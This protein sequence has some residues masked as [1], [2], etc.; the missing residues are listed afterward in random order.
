MKIGIVCEGGGMRGSYT[1]GV[2]EAFM[3][4]GFVAD[5]LVGVSAG[6]SNG[7]SYVSGQQGRGIRTNLDYCN[8]KRYMGVRSY[9]KTGSFFGM[10]FIFGEIPNKL[11]PFDWEAF[12]ASPCAFYAGVTDVETGRAVFFGKRDIRPGLAVL[13][14]SCSI[15]VLSP[16]VHYNGGQYLD[17]GV[18]APIPIDKALEDGC[19]RLV[20]ILTRQRGYR[21]KPQHMR[22]LYKRRFANHPD[23]EKAIG[24]RY[25][26]YNHT[27][28]RLE[29][30]E[31]EGKAIVIAPTTQLPVD[32]MARDRAKLEQA[33]NQ[34][35][36]DGLAALPV[37]GR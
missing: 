8:D 33:C 10:D 9:V 22:L 1:A 35:I 27:L 18:A 23:M 15:P 16:V 4:E 14:A 5:E 19:D 17:G 34:G 13:R 29:R 26:V 25:M 11:D 7:V 31:Q 12:Y 6:A 32:R 21:K 3:R 20:V 24:L 36:Q 28:E 2:L 37:I 30:L